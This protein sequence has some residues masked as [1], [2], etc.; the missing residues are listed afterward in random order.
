MQE[1]VLQAKALGLASGGPGAPDSVAS[2]LG[3][4]GAGS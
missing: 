4:V 1:V 3:Q 2:F